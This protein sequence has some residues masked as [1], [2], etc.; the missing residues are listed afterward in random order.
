MSDPK[1]QPLLTRRPIICTRCMH[2]NRVEV[3]TGREKTPTE[4]NCGCGNYAIVGVPARWPFME[5]VKSESKPVQKVAQ[6][7]HDEHG[8]SPMQVGE[9]LVKSLNNIPG[10]IP[11]RPQVL[12]TIADNIDEDCKQEEPMPGKKRNPECKREGC[13]MEGPFHGFC[14]K[15]FTAEYGIS[16]NQYSRAKKYRGEDPRDVAIR[17]KAAGMQ[18]SEQKTPKREP[19]PA[20]AETKGPKA[21]KKAPV[22]ETKP[23]SNDVEKQEV[24]KAEPPALTPEQE[25]KRAAYEQEKKLGAL[26]PRP[27]IGLVGKDYITIVA[28]EEFINKIK[29]AADRDFRTP[30]LQVAYYL[31]RGMEACGV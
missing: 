26:P 10:N 18:E 9:S 17:I 12:E 11:R 3:I 25:E 15:D 1:P 7:D 8:S 27:P 29:E 5:V 30:G 22:H 21:E 20:A 24:G 23:P 14:A 19:K 31:A 6:S 2:G 4:Y 16:Y 13:A 28:K